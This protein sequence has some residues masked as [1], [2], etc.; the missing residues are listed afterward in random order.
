MLLRRCVSCQFLCSPVLVLCLLCYGLVSAAQ[1]GTFRFDNVTHEQGLPD[2]IINSIVQD[3]NGF[4]WFGSEEGLTRYD[5]YS[6][7]VYRHDP[8]DPHSLSD[9][10]VYA[11]CLDGD[12]NLWV[13]TRNGLNRYDALNN[14]F[15]VFRHNV[16]DDRTI[17]SDEIFSLA[18]D[19]SGTLWIG[20]YGGGIDKLEKQPSGYV[21]LHHRH[22]ADDPGSVSD[23][24]VFA[25]AFDPSGNCYAGTAKGLDIRL[26]GTAN[27]IHFVH[28]PGTANS[29]STNAVS[30]IFTAPDGSVWLSG[31]NMLDRI[32]ADK[33]SKTYIV[34]HI[35]PLIARNIPGEIVVND[36][37]I[38]ANNNA[39]LATNDQGVLRFRFSN[40]SEVV[41][42]VQY[43]HQQQNPFSLAAS[44]VY[45]LY[46]DR[47]GVIWIGTSKGVSKF[48]PAKEVFGR[49]EW[50]TVLPPGRFVL[51]V[52]VDQ[53]GRVWFAPDGDSI[54]VLSKTGSAFQATDRR[55]IS[56][57]LA[58][59]GFDQ[60]NIL[61]TTATGDICIGTMLQGFFIIPAALTNKTDKRNWLHVDVKHFPALP[62][63]NIYAFADDGTGN[64]WVGTYKGLCRFNIAT[65]QLTPHYVSEKAYIVSGYIIRSILAEDSHNIWCG[66]D[67][68]IVKLHDG[69]PVYSYSQA[70]GATGRLSNNA[71]IA[72]HKDKQGTL[73][74]GTKEGINL[75]TPG[76]KEV[77][78]MSV[79]DGLPDAG[80]RSIVEDRQGAIWVAT[81]HGLARF[82]ATEKRFAAFTVRDGLP[83]DQFVTNSACVAPEGMLY[84]GTNDGLITFHPQ[85]IIANR[86]VPPVVITQ[87]KVMNRDIAGLGDST[88]LSRFRNDSVL[89]L[90]YNQNFFSF[91]FAALNY[92]NT[93]NN[94]YAYQLEGVDED[95][96]NAGTSRFAGY[97]DIQPGH[98]VFKVKAANNDG[99]WNDTPVSL[100]VIIDP[101][102]WHTW[103]FYTLCVLVLCVILFIIYR[104]R[105]R[106]VLQLYRLR[107]SIAKDLHD[108]VGSALSSIAMLSR[109]AQDGRSV[110][111]LKPEEVFTR[112][113][114]TSKRMI[115]LMDDIV[116]SVNPDNDRFSNMLVRMR[117]Y[118]VEMLEPLNID[119]AFQVPG[120]LEAI[121]I[122][123]QLRKD[124]FLLFKE[125]V[126]NTAKYSGCTKTTITITRQNRQLQTVIAD[127]GKGFDTSVITS[128]NGLH[129]M[130][131]RAAAM[132]GTLHINSKPGLGTTVSLTI[133]V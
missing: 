93:G 38:D 36:F 73:W 75:V 62:S 104:V 53:Q 54:I 95:W 124:Y 90:S 87:V 92:I 19:A 63:N 9:N 89:H 2:R 117:E 88:M 114:D 64:I 66:T 97:T 110:A 123:M 43:T 31:Y 56:P 96:I 91:E 80:V 130:Q 82:N 107:S 14:R 51:A 102:W 29:I 33:T 83:A 30:K 85:S 111:R 6:C 50:A 129:N 42:T 116:W 28:Q 70:T 72:L 5:G 3:A 35:L 101:P 65:Q 133:P 25:L 16:A 71:V 18:A 125:A 27:F 67:E 59:D 109:I 127:N 10:A 113:G 55:I 45:C 20:A 24:Q 132:K 68:G 76:K 37:R 57:V 41:N 78:V 121:R 34:Q 103:W 115:D 49:P 79:L 81:S 112:I 52:T 12:G 84:F 13:G 1:P 105:V 106:Q 58:A 40:S 26:A 108:D 94:R 4:I 44:N 119:I 77:V 48:I 15:D 22:N 69:K 21:F 23:N 86:Y 118:A 7:I 126:N 128:G 74:V 46:E 39:W 11:L 17:A 8:N 60:V 99:I 100:R 120:D 122:P 61:Y 98:Y 32:V 131:S 47:S